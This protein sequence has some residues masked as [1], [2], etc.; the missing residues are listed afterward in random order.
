MLKCL[1]L[2]LMISVIGVLSSNAI[3]QNCVSVKTHMA[4]T[5]SLCSADTT[6][7][8]NK[9]EIPLLVSDAL[10]GDKKAAARLAWYYDQILWDG[11]GSKYWFQIAAENGDASAMYNLAIIYDGSDSQ[12]DNKRAIFWARKASVSDDKLIVP[13]ANKLLIDIS[14]RKRGHNH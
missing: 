10:N 14:K 2:L 13:L 8:I 6:F 11:R 12:N 3:G 1:L 9:K 5:T 4:T 7:E